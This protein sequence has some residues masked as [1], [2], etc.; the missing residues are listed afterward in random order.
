MS[1]ALEQA[2]SEIERGAVESLDSAQE[3]EGA[4]AE[5]GG[6]DRNGAAGD[7]SGRKNRGGDHRRE[8]GAK[9]R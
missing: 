4:C 2:L 8:T 5:R 3:E 7:R 9:G 1:P 6:V